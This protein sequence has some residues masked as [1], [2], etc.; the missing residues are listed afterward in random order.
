MTEVD[1]IYKAKLPYQTILDSSNLP[2]VSTEFG[3]QSVVD[4]DASFLYLTN[5]TRLTYIS[6]VANTDLTTEAFNEDLEYDL[7]YINADKESRA[8]Y[9]GFDGSNNLIKYY[10]ID[11]HQAETLATYQLQ[12]ANG[13][14]LT[15][16]PS[17][18][19]MHEDLLVLAYGT[20]LYFFDVNIPITT[21]ITDGT[22]EATY[23]KAFLTG[24]LTTAATG[25]SLMNK[26]SILLHYPK[27]EFIANTES[28]MT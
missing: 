28:I 7:P 17:A 22:T 10:W 15:N 9:Y 1:V 21:Y 12:D 6:T 16:A 4:T 2:I 18:W 5:P 25:L 8:M 14:P 26:K 13:A 27:M 24:T 20:D 3:T 11:A 23:C 19:A